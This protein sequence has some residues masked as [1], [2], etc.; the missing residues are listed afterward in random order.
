VLLQAAIQAQTSDNKFS[1]DKDDIIYQLK[2]WEGTCYLSVNE[3]EFGYSLIEGVSTKVT[4][5]FL[6]EHTNLIWY[7]L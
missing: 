3:M 4:A 6:L 1:L 7:N 2:D 5:Y